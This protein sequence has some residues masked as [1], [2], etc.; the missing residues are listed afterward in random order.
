[1]FPFPPHFC[2]IIPLFLLFKKA[3]MRRMFALQADKL[4]GPPY[5]INIQTWNNWEWVLEDQRHG[6]RYLKRKRCAEDSCMLNPLSL[7]LTLLVNMKGL[8]R[9]ISHHVLPSDFLEEC[10]MFRSD[11]AL[12][13]HPPYTTLFIC[14][15]DAEREWERRRGS[16]FGGPIYWSRTNFYANAM[17]WFERNGYCWGMWRHGWLTVSQHSAADRADT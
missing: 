6:N 5:I 9:S 15:C 4:K 14:V 1:M 10:S 11:W 2:P 12:K 16:L 8:L 3:E 13:E 17:T 7:P